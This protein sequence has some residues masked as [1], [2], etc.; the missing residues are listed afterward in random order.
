MFSIKYYRGETRLRVVQIWVARVP[1]IKYGNKNYQTHLANVFIRILS[2]LL[3]L[4][5][6]ILCCFNF[7]VP[8]YFV[9]KYTSIKIQHTSKQDSEEIV[10]F[11]LLWPKVWLEQIC[12]EV[13]VEFR[14]NSPAATV[15]LSAKLSLP[16]LRNGKQISSLLGSIEKTLV[17]LCTLKTLPCLKKLF[18]DV[19]VPWEKMP[20]W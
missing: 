18:S 1:K 20:S 2:V 8:K 9:I 16:G 13:V 11:S 7:L 14:A 10:L 6:E 4:R 5:A 3:V 19:A 15:A 12:R 17:C